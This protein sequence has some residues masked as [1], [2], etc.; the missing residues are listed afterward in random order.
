VPLLLPV[1]VAPLL[2]RR[3]WPFEAA[4]ALF[5]ATV[6]SGIPTFD[7]FRLGLAIPVVAFTLASRCELPRSLTGLAFVLAGMVFVGETDIVLRDHGGVANM[8][9]FSFPLCLASWGAGRVA[10]S[11]DRLS[12]RL[13]AQSRL[14]ERQRERTAKLAVKVERTRLASELDVAARAQVRAMIALPTMR[15]GARQSTRS[16]RERPSA[17]SSASAVMRSTRCAICS[18]SFVVMNADRAARA[19]R[20]RRSRRCW[21]RR[22][23]GGGLSIWTCTVSAGRFR[24]ASSWRATARFSTRSSPWTVRP[25][26]QRR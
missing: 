11:R 1:V 24:S 18:G 22:V 9:L 26:R 25:I 19:P 20:S 10:W 14:L 15:C 7:Q 12:G 16:A 3:R 17:G 13:A 2:L 21:P 4:V 23:L 6:L 8:I 5:A